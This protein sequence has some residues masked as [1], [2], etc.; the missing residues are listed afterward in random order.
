M[1]QIVLQRLNVIGVRIHK[2]TT[3]PPGDRKFRKPAP[4]CVAFGGLAKGL[5]TRPR[6]TFRFEDQ[7]PFGHGPT[8][9]ELRV[10]PK[11]EPHVRY[12]MAQDF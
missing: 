9:N 10:S 5:T 8:P 1:R 12:L 4:H 3:A 11:P 7:G 2:K 6:F